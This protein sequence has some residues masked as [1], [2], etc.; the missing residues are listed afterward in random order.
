MSDERIKRI[1]YSIILLIMLMFLCAN[2]NKEQKTDDNYGWAKHING[3]TV[4]VTIFADDSNTTWDKEAAY[5]EARSQCR[6]YIKIACDWVSEQCKKYA[7]SPEFIYDWN[8]DPELNKRAQLAGNITG[9]NPDTKVIDQ[10]LFSEQYE[11]LRRQLLDRY[12]ADSIA[13]LFVMNTPAEHKEA[14]ISYMHMNDEDPD[15]EFIILYNYVNHEQEGPSVYAHELL[16]L[17]GAPDLYESGNGG[18]PIS[19]EYSQYLKENK[20]DDIMYSV[21]TDKGNMRY[22]KVAR[23]LSEVDAY[24]LGMIPRPSECDRF[25]LGDSLFCTK[26]T[27][28][29]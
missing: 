3:R 18:V 19:A 27:Y 11:A 24:Y 16:H 17:F 5:T 22:D 8:D 2:S 29:P 26:N 1:I 9:V 28:T 12:E 21:Y 14:S 4:I 25:N 15:D 20:S 6:Q 23:N 10:L 13:F 7:A